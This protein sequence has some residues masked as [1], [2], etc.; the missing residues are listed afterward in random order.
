[1]ARALTHAEVQRASC[2]ESA[3][4]WRAQAGHVR[5]HAECL[6]RR[7]QPGDAACAARLRREAEACERQAAWWLEGIAA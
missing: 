7:G 6:E 5:D 2:L 3:A 4:R 1:M